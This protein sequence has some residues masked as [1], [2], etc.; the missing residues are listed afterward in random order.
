MDDKET[1]ISRLSRLYLNTYNLLSGRLLALFALTKCK[2]EAERERTESQQY[3][4]YQKGQIDMLYE[5]FKIIEDTDL[6][7]SEKRHEI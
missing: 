6:R 2:I 5:V 3:T 1:R 4:E 7:F